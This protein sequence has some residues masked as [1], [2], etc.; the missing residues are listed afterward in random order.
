MNDMLTEQFEEYHNIVEV[1]HVKVE[2]RLSQND[3]HQALER[4]IEDRREPH[5]A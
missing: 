5:T 2:L 1:A 4:R 3:V